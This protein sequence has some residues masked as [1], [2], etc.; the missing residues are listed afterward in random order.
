MKGD[1][2]INNTPEKETKDSQEPVQKEARQAK[3]MTLPLPQIL[4][5]LES[6][7]KRV[8]EAVKQAQ[9]AAKDSREA[10]TQAQVSGE[11]AAEAARKAADTAVA[12][13]KEESSQ[14]IDILGKKVSDL[15]TEL[16]TLK[17]K[18]SQEALALDKAFLALKERH[19]EES[20]F[21]EK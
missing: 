17:D 4:D 19:I 7:I 16:N 9:T 21:P 8:E 2:Q 14:A 11:K 6:Y 1:R 18:V 10:A 5:E 15:E 3:I 13:V 12:K 20:P